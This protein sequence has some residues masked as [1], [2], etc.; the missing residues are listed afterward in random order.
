LGERNSL[1]STKEKNATASPLMRELFHLGVYKR[2]QGRI[3]RQVTFAVLAVVVALGAW[4]LNA[5]LIGQESFLLRFGLPGVMLLLGWWIA[6]R[7]VNLPSFADFLIA[8]EAE[9]NKVSWPTRGELFRSVL[10]VI[11]F[12]AF[13]VVVL[14][15]YDVFWRFLLQN[16]LHVLS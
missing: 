15:F 1:M 11:F 7:L 16:V 10:V 12:I 5:Y 2:S 4:R 3:A 9:M 6:F 13:L 14:A 8:V